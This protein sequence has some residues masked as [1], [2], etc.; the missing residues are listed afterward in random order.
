[1]YSLTPLSSS[2]SSA[3]LSLSL[4]HRTLALALNNWTNIHH[5]HAF[6]TQNSKRD[7]YNLYYGRVRFVFA[8]YESNFTHTGS[9]L[10]TNERTNKWMDRWMD[11]WIDNCI[12]C[13]AFMPNH[14]QSENMS[15][16]K[17]VANALNAFIHSFG[18]FCSCSS[19]SSSILF[20]PLSRSLT[21]FE[22]LM[23]F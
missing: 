16:P 21:D 15:A 18:L 20:H 10:W 9:N 2:S 8:C 1:M 5:V 19:Y 13:F 3:S 23:V 6:K 17:T 22:Y 4:S 7:D 11:V 14:R 12:L